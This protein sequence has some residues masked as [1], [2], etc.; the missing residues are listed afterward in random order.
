MP[1]LNYN[2]DSIECAYE[3]DYKDIDKDV[4]ENNEIYLDDDLIICSLYLPV[5]RIKNKNCEKEKN[6]GLKF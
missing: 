2:N 3:N 5:N 4:I 6:R 1:E